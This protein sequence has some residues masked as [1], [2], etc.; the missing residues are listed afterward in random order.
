MVQSIISSRVKEL[1]Q[2]EATICLGILKRYLDDEESVGFDEDLD[3][4]RILLINR[5]NPL[6]DGYLS[7]QLP[8]GDFKTQIDSISKTQ[9]GGRTEVGDLWG[10]KGIKGM[11]FFNLLHRACES[12]NTDIDNLLK[13][14]ICVPS[15]RD[16]AFRKM[17]E[18][19]QKV[20]DIQGEF[21]DR[22]RAPNPRSVPYFLT[23]FWQIQAPGTWPIQYT[24]L[25]RA[26]EL[27][28]LW[29]K[30]DDIVANYD[31][32]LN[33]NLELKRLFG[34]H[35]KREFNLW[36]V[37]HVFY[38]YYKN[39]SDYLSQ[40]DASILEG[41]SSTGI[42]T[43]EPEDIVSPL[44]K[45]LPRSYVPPI[46]SVIPKLAS[47]DDEIQQLCDEAGKS[48]AK[49]LEERV[50]DAFI[51]LGLEVQR[52]GQGKG[53]VPD[54]IALCREYHY[55]IIYDTK[56]TQYDY[57][58]GTDSRA[59]IEYVRSHA[60]RL[61]KQGVEKVFFVVVSSSFAEEME[62][63]IQRIKMTPGIQ[64]VVLIPAGSLVKLVELKLR[65]HDFDLGP[66]GFLDMLTRG[67]ML[68]ERDLEE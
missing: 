11:M 10:F 9:K 57:S 52:L 12:Q 39:E 4:R 58:I 28:G 27:L 46:I 17:E 50:A 29:T 2:E 23:Y 1:N 30:G 60:P 37:E 7:G 59:F 19:Y 20:S 47:N 36:Q 43:E 62:S 34:E 35:S 21:E 49:E 18:L 63:E 24:S 5:I 25:E 33:L 13:P 54:G 64:E 14:A 16:E 41:I 66:Y 3:E 48:V 68:L 15:D 44:L 65:T 26:F 22:R 61:R 53:R 56:A 31:S 45:T 55:A 42:T 51:M 40:P 67:G 6:I 38:Y 8:I 32:F